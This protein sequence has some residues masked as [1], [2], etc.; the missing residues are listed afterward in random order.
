MPAELRPQGDA[1]ADARTVRREVEAVAVPRIE[2]LVEREGGE[3]TSRVVVLDGDLFKLGSHPANN[4]VLSDR[5]VSRFHCQLSTT[6]GAWRIADSGSLNGT[7]IDG[8]RVRDADLPMPVCRI[9][10]GDSIVR[11]TALGSASD[12]EVPG[13]ISF[14]ALYGGSLAM[15]RLYALL[16]KLAR[17]DANVL[18]EGESGTGKELVAAELAQRGRRADCPFVIVDCGAVSPNLIESELFGHVRGAFTGASRDRVGAFEAADGGTLFLDEV[19]EMPL[20]MQ[21]KL[22]RALEAHDVRRIGENRVRKVD[23]RVIAA[24]NRRLEREVNHGRFREDLYFR[25]SVVSVRVPPLRE[26]LEDL[27]T[28]VDV[29]LNAMSATE[30]ASLFTPQVLADMARYDWPGNVRELRN[31]V[32]RVVVLDKAPPTSS[33]ANTIYGMS[34]NAPATDATSLDL[35]FAAGKERVITEYERRYLSDLLKWA[36]GN[37]SRAARKAGMDRMHL[38]RL[39]Q[40]HELHGASP[41]GLGGDTERKPGFGGLG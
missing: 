14:G 7:R 16:D 18:I 13:W 19:G 32:A 36:G 34:R 31:Y 38:Y 37:V 39:L 1:S 35:S 33:R 11:V 40:K 17:S 5:G 23:A 6:G 28:L 15:R 4:V 41:K 3:P 10:L 30:K 26:R 2:L 22:L 29:L 21:P 8:T 20:D 9:E 27:R 24:T 25:L 12:A